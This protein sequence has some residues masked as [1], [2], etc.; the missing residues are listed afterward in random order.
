M[1]RGEYG[2]RKDVPD[3]RRVF[4]AILEAIVV[5]VS[6]RTRQTRNSIQFTDHVRSRRLGLKFGFV[7]VSRR[8]TDIML[9][10][11]CKN[12]ENN[13]VQEM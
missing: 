5:V 12:N 10:C 7:N 13:N 3:A 4:K 1:S 11:D 2:E 9:S 6:W 8:F